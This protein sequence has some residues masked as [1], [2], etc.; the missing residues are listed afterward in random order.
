[1]IHLLTLSD[2]EF[3][4]LRQRMNWG[5]FESPFGLCSVGWTKQGIV[6]LAFHADLRDRD[7]DGHT[8][9]HLS[10]DWTLLESNRDDTTVQGLGKRVYQSEL[11]LSPLTVL[12]G[13][14]VFQ[15]RVWQALTQI[16]W[17]VVVSYGC[18][19]QK[20]G[21]PRVARAVGAA[22]SVNPVGYLIPCHRVILGSGGIEG[23]R[24][25]TERKMR[26][27][28]AEGFRVSSPRQRCGASL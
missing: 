24:W 6:H 18:L 1:M 16:P 28:E 8:F 27:L 26:L 2:S 14:T 22:C 4:D 11:F 12:V 21:N 10:Q 23:Y 15:R 9:S 3:V 7:A 25:G 17:G 5:W 20:I 19:A 13:G